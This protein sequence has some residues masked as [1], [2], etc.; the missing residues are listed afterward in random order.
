MEMFEKENLECVKGSGQFDQMNKDWV[1]Q[2]QYVEGRRALTCDL[3]KLQ[4]GA[5]SLV[6]GKR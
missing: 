3:G 5:P 1:R 2:Q 4:A 6:D